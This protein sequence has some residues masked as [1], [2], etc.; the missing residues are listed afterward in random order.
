VPAVEVLNVAVIVQVGVHVPRLS[1]GA[2]KPVVAVEVNVGSTV[3]NPGKPFSDV[4]VIVTVGEA[5]PLKAV[6][7]EELD[8]IATQVGCTELLRVVPV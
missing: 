4:A 3:K 7:L 5:P 2:V 8:V 1:V 6:T